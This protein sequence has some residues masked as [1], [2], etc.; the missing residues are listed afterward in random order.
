MRLFHIAEEK[1]TLITK[2][3]LYAAAVAFFLCVLFV[4]YSKLYSETKNNIINK[5]EI[6]AMETSDQISVRM[7][8]SMDIIKLASYSIDNMIKENRSQEEI[9]EY[10]VSETEAVGGSLI[11][12]TTGIYGYING[13]Y[14]DGSGWVPEEGYDPA[15]RPWYTEAK[16]GN[17]EIVLVDPYVDLD[18]GKIMIALARLL[19]DKSSVVGIDL[20]MDD[21][22]YI[23]EKQVKDGYSYAEFIVSGSGRVISHSDKDMI[24]KDLY[25]GSDPL[26]AEITDRLGQPEASYCYLNYN[27]MDYMLYFMPLDDNWM[28]VSV[29]DATDDFEKLRTPL[30]TTA[31]ISVIIIAIFLI[32]L[33]FSEKK[34]RKTRELSLKSERAVAASEAKTAF[35]SNMSHEIRTPVN[36]ILGMNEM[37]LREADDESI[38]E[39]S[40]SIKNA[41]AA[42]LG[43]INDVLDF[44]KIEAG[45][46]EIYP[47]D[48]DL[49]SVINDLVL[50]IHNRADEKGLIL[51]LDFDRTTPKRLVGDEIRIKQV[52]TNILTNAVKY[53][54]KGSVTFSIGYHR[55]QDDPDSVILDVSVKD[56]GIGIKPED[57]E[58]LFAK[59]E[60]IE[61]ARNRNIEGTGLGMNITSSLLELMGSKLEVSSKYGAGS[62]FG[63][64]LKQ[65]VIN[66]EGLGD[67]EESY[68]NHI[69]NRTS[70]IERIA[71]PNARVIVVDD[72][73][74]N[75]TVIRNLIKQTK[76]S[77]DTAEG[78]YEFLRM[79][80]EKQYDLIFLDH[81]MPGMDG[82]ETLQEL[83][84]DTYNT[85]SGVPVICLTANAISGA[86]EQYISAG[87]DDYLTKPVDYE[88]LE[89]MLIRY[90]PPDKITQVS[91]ESE[92]EN[93]AASAD[94]RLWALNGQGG[95]NIETGIRNN[96]S[97]DAYLSV[98]KIFYDSLEE[99]AEELEEYFVSENVKDYTIKVH[100]LKSSAR[101]IGAT[102]FGD[103]AQ[104]LEM[105]GKIGDIE[106]I[107]EHHKAFIDEYR[108]YKSI[109]APY[110]DIKDEA[111]I[112]DK[113]V[114]D[115]VLMHEA[116]NSVKEA[117]N[118]MDCDKLE[119]VIEDMK[120]YSIPDEHI[121]LW[122]MICQAADQFDYSG[123]IELLNQGEK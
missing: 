86:K 28:C 52:I 62:V 22:Q 107:K 10:M 95:I 83:K 85:N 16:R 116:L 49:S 25:E 44:S 68:R 115:N 24:G 69:K 18:T 13:E 113:P 59:F 19:S 111:D 66:W 82:I 100:A 65:K 117:A 98:L 122:D 123:I 92:E 80:K 104:K 2:T 29:I 63:F 32:L 72:N 45:K 14:L 6:I 23:I 108:T 43:L 48:Y 90:L 114:A 88:R 99:K 102:E 118:D 64:C 91:Y 121:K 96:G 71:A 56:T 58:K 70:F 76:I 87:F 9:Y 7:S 78:G 4:Y 97:A 3:L 73:P 112:D 38:L 1:R 20:S 77:V 67:Y 57:I 74:M 119:S 21:I 53:T 27:N 60:R 101:I 8:S 42:L 46:I 26:T 40:Y 105:A 94:D 61:E 37:I 34:D 47:V 93:K 17:G 41:G 81:M 54:E 51:N 79:S 36:A 30:V 15:V 89:D 106:Y 120:A 110:I 55:V 50:M 84:A 5:G 33:A 31:F 103:K 109:I 12:D 39:Y 35:L 75:L 11:A